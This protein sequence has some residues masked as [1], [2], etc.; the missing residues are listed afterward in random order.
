MFA[1][2]IMTPLLTPVV[3]PVYMSA[4]TSSQRAAFSTGVSGCWL[5]SGRNSYIPASGGTFR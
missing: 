2:V 3:P 4:P 1:W 5:I